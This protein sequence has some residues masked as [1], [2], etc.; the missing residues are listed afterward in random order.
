MIY[1]RWNSH[2]FH[3]LYVPGVREYKEGAAARRCSTF[4]GLCCPRHDYDQVTL[5][6]RDFYTP[7]FSSE[8]WIRIRRIHN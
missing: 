8:M 6:E 7:E 3:D 1:L 4:P 2:I 5:A